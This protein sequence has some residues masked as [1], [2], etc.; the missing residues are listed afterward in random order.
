MLPHLDIYILA[1]ILSI[2]IVF[3]FC[4]YY[5]HQKLADYFSIFANIICLLITATYL[6]YYITI[7]H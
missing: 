3:F 2:I 7:T 4:Y 5:K 1:L 6:I